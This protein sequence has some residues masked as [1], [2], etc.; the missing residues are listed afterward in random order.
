MVPL[1]LGYYIAGT[2]AILLFVIIVRRRSMS[3]K[4]K[5]IKEAWAGSESTFDIET[6]RVFDRFTA[7]DEVSGGYRADDDTWNDFDLD[8]IFTLINRAVTPIGAQH[9]FHLLRHPVS[10]PSELKA[11]EKLIDLFSDN[12]HLREQIQLALYR[13]SDKNAR[14][15]PYSLWKPLPDRPWYAAALPF[16]SYLSCITLFLALFT[17]ISFFFLIPVFFVNLGIRSYVKRRIEIYIQSFQY[18]GVL[19][20][21]A[22]GITAVKNEDLRD[23][24]DR[25]TSDLKDTRTIAGKIFTMQFKDEMGF[26]EYIN[27]FFLWDIAGFYSV[28][29]DLT[30]HIRELRAIYSTVG[31]LDA[32]ISIASFRTRFPHFCRPALHAGNGAFRLKNIY[33]P[34]LANPVPNT[35]IFD[36]R[37]VLIT[38]SNMAGKT[39]FLKTMGV[40]AILAQTIHT[41]MAEEYEAPFVTVISSMGISDNLVMGKSYYLAEVESI[42]RLLRASDTDTVH[43]FFLDEIFR[44]TNSVERRAIS[45]EVMKYL[46]NGKDYIL[47]ATHDLHLAE[48]LSQTYVNYHFREKVGDG[49]LIFDYTI[50]AGPSTTRNA[51]ALLEYAGYPKSIVSNARGRVQDSVNNVLYE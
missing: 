11:R 21:A 36:S 6:A 26:N 15:L 33:N 47:L 39:T 10:D 31:Y 27:T 48:I 28:V 40:N 41:C 49:G 20:K 24:Q 22:E 19:I 9:L 14:F 46:A 3:R 43:L 5:K 51:I 2:A 7:G 23:I 38:G 1:I 4:K 13:L 30:K 8:K 45:I 29:G 35:F 12:Q 37:N 32:M 18:L 44:G 16:I 34:L 17:F 42:L 50:H 25:L